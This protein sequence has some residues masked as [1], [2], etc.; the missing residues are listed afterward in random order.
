MKQYFL[1]LGKTGAPREGVTSQRKCTANYLKTEKHS[2]PMP[3]L[4]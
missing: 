4:L 1:K 2:K 3:I